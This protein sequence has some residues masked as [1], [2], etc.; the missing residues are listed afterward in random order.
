MLIMTAKLPRRALSLGVLTAAALGLV[1][2]LLAL[3]SP[4]GQ[5]GQTAA[6]VRPAK[7]RTNEDR[8]AYLAEYGW[9]VKEDPLTVEELIVPRSFDEPYDEYLSLQAEQG[10]DLTRY[11]GKRIRRYCYAVTN[12]PGQPGDVRADLLIYRNTVIGGEVLSPTQDGFLHGLAG[13]ERA[14]DQAPAG[15]ALS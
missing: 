10:F 8:I 4:R 3:L 2:L 11:A 6:A 12:Y 13:P 7:L 5:A 14:P 1:I 9:E 15:A